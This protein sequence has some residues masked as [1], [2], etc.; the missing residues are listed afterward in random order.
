MNG[1]G[2]LR[3]AMT[4]ALVAG[5]CGIILGAAYTTTKP[6][7]DFIKDEELKNSLTQVLPEA[8][9][10]TLR[11]APGNQTYFAGYAGDKF[12]GYAF[13]VESAGYSSVIEV[14]VGVDGDGTVLGAKVL[15]QQE[16]PGLG[17]RIAEVRVG[18]DKP[19]FMAQF[20]GKR[21]VHLRLSKYGGS[22]DAITGATVSSTAVSEGLFKGVSDMMEV[23]EAD[24]L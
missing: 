9:D 11:N 5:L 19:W 2:L 24:G 12:V 1:N 4:L 14:L 3:Q 7:I 20:E 18:E 16:T 6:R 23:I 8:S 17:A 22:V 15:G 13:T 21:G 10:F